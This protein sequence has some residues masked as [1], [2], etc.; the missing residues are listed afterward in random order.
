MKKNI[1]LSTL[2]R[3]HLKTGL[4][5][6]MP[7]QTI[8]YRLHLCVYLVWKQFIIILTMQFANLPRSYRILGKMM[9]DVGRHCCKIS[10]KILED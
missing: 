6:V 9:K 5:R 7:S 3:R 8:I 2:S 4:G 10:Y 1:A